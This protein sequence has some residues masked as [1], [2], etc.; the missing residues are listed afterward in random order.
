MAAPAVAQDRPRFTLPDTATENL[1]PPRPP[2]D[3]SAAHIFT[4]DGLLETIESIPDLLDESALLD[5]TDAF[6]AMGADSGVVPGLARHDLHVSVQVRGDWSFEH[7]GRSRGLSLPFD[8]GSILY[9][10]NVH[11]PGYAY[12]WVIATRLPDEPATTRHPL[13]SQLAAHL[14][15]PPDLR[16]EPLTAAFGA[17]AQHLFRPDRFDGRL[18][19]GLDWLD[20]TGSGLFEG[21]F[22]LVDHGHLHASL[23]QSEG[24]VMRL[25]AVVREYEDSGPALTPRPTGQV[26]LVEILIC[27]AELQESSPATCRDWLTE[28]EPRLVEALNAAED[29][30]RQAEEQM[31]ELTAQAE[32]E[33]RRAEGER[34]AREQV[35]D[36]YRRV[37]AELE[38]I[39]TL[40]LARRLRDEALRSA[41]A[42][43]ERNLAHSELLAAESN[44]IHERSE[45]ASDRYVE[46]A[47]RYSDALRREAMVDAR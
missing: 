30:V 16:N 9:R 45:S 42:V 19:L 10:L 14:G 43:R 34:N 17:A 32:A 8:D 1:P 40:E 25:V 36:A 37:E 27:P 22:T 46:A 26:G 7:Q 18:M 12:P 44:M 21:T 4:L 29:A 11:L 24:P 38:R 3:I 35:A 2:I 20:V 41:E 33:F 15:N 23:R 5:N 28:D 13:I 6:Q 31:R 39:E 47:V